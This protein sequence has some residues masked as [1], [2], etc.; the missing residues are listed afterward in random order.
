M[1]S[2]NPFNLPKPFSIFH[3]NKPIRRNNNRLSNHFL[4]KTFSYNNNIF[5]SDEDENYIN[6]SLFFNEPDREED[7]EDDLYS[8]NLSNRNIFLRNYRNQR[9]N[10]MQSQKNFYNNLLSTRNK[11]AELDNIRKENQKKFSNL[12]GK[13]KNEEKVEILKNL[14]EIKNI[15]E[16]NKNEEIQKQKYLDYLDKKIENKKKEKQKKMEQREINKRLI[17]KEMLNAK[18]NEE[19]I[20]LEKYKKEKKLKKNKE[21]KEFLLEKNQFKINI[22]LKLNELKNKSDIVP[23]LQFYFENIQ[24]T[25]K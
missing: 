16:E 13:Y 10:E 12:V 18:Y 17:Q 21:E 2:F 24:K 5:D 19:K 9:E 25:K 4:N 1:I 22:D 11:I 3:L 20:K 7:D 14:S 6:K 23:K 8:F 15:L